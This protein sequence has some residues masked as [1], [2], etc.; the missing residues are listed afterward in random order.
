VRS[1]LLERA[2]EAEEVLLFLE[3]EVAA[4]RVQMVVEVVRHV[5]R[6]HRALEVV[7]STD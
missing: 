1:V 7:G 2:Q 6:V 5:L 4:L 3:V